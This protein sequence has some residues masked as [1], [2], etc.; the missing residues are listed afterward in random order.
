MKTKILIINFIIIFIG[1]EKC[2]GQ[3]FLNGD[4]EFNL[5]SNCEYNHSDS[6]FNTRISD[7]FAFGKNNYGAS[8][9]GQTD[10]QTKGCFVTPQHGDWC[11]GLSG[12]RFTD[13]TSDAIA[14]KLSS[15]LTAGFKYQLSFYLFGN[16]TFSDTLGDI[17]VGES[18][19]PS[20]IGRIIDTIS[21]IAMNWKQVLLNFEATQSSQY[22]TIK[23]VPGLRSWNQIDNF[24]IKLITNTKNYTK[25]TPRIILY[26][27]PVQNT[28]T[29]ESRK[30][31]KFK[32][33]RIMNE[34]G[35]TVFN[36]K[37]LSFDINH[38][39]PGMYFV[40]IITDKGSIIKHV[41]KI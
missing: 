31:N 3:F 18:D 1:Y 21:P 38:L 41:I 29:I 14:L 33:V 30:L 4:F 2:F 39:N 25:E 8:L 16:T 37:L 28:L 20:I 7:V 32:S 6:I 10:I 24:E 36:T 11:I 5:A 40:E 17:V 35:I 9:R 23:N 26:P 13:T 19:S 34:F 12:E 22:I 15:T 27:N